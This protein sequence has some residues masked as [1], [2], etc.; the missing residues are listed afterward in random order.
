[1]AP[2]QLASWLL[3]LMVSSVPPGQSN[4]PDEA[5]ESA[6][7][8][9]IRYAEIADALAQV[10]LDPAEKP[11]FDGKLGRERTAALLLAL[12]Y[13]ES[14]LRRDVDLGLG[15]HARGAGRYWCLMQVAIAKERTA[16]GWTGAA[17]IASRERCFRAGLHILQRSRGACRKQGPD[18]WLR[19]Y[20]SGHCERG[21][22]S[23]DKRLGTLRRWL[24]VRPPPAP[25]E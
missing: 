7:Q 11:V 6:E 1:M 21:R 17:L 12:A 20:T 13:H 24:R 5:R 15:R 4:F 10:S 23:A 14:G 19:L 22:E 16:D 3:S 8:G 25:T 18:A 2:N 9:R